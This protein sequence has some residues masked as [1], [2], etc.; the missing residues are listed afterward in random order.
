MRSF[1]VLDLYKLWTLVSKSPPLYSVL[2]E[3]LCKPY[4]ASVDWT[5]GWRW[6]QASLPGLLTLANCFASAA[7]VG[8][9]SS[10]LQFLFLFIFQDPV[11]YVTSEARHCSRIS[12]LSFAALRTSTSPRCFL[13]HRRTICLLAFLS[14]YCMSYGLSIRSP[15]RLKHWWITL[16]GI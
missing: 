15:H 13:S 12:P 7:A 3:E 16:E 14:W 11:T 2:R 9:C 6:V 4:L 10:R 5:W 1:P 8:F